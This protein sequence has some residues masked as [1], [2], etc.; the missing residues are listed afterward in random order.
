MCHQEQPSIIEACAVISA[1]I[2]KI[3]DQLDGTELTENEIRALRQCELEMSKLE[4]TAWRM[5]CELTTS[6]ALLVETDETVQR[7]DETI[8]SL[9]LGLAP[10][11][12]PKRHY[13][14]DF[15]FG[16]PGQHFG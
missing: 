8:D 14:N 4:A 16:V 10:A 13:T 11:Q 7:I 1:Q 5:L 2:A 9:G 12:S 3:S 15:G 6:D